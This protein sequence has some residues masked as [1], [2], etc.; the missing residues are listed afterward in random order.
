M[1][2]GTGYTVETEVSF[3]TEQGT[4]FGDV[5]LRDPNG[6]IVCVFECKTGSGASKPKQVRKDAELYQEK[7][8]RTIKVT[9]GFL[10]HP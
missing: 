2:E 10:Y 6:K 5:V 9:P 4:R 8:I 1:H 7:D 3:Q